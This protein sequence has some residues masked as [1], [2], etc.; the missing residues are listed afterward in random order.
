MRACRWPAAFGISLLLCSCIDFNGQTLTYRYDRAGD[1][2]LM[3]VV[4]EAIHVA[5]EDKAGADPPVTDKEKEQLESVNRGRRAFFFDNWISE[6]DG[7]RI[8]REIGEARRKLAEA[9]PPAD[10]ARL[11]ADVEF[12]EAVIKTVR[13]K[14]GRFYLNGK[15]QL[16]GWQYVTVSGVSRLLPLINAWAK[17]MVQDMKTEGLGDRARQRLRALVDKEDWVRIDG[18]QIRI[19]IVLP[20]DD[21]AKN[22]KEMMNDSRKPLDF[23]TQDAVLNYDEPVAEVIL[24]RLDQETTTL[25]RPAEDKSSGALVAYVKEKYGLVPEPDLEKLR[26]EFIRSGKLPEG[27]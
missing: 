21:F 25:S 16:C 12:F 10:R 26:R 24:G 14:N 15:G 8:E 1:T 27:D 19:R 5:A 6:F 20:Y 22:R 9:V 11:K 7:E 13:V 23:R 2:L 18:N 3:F 17:R 4:Y